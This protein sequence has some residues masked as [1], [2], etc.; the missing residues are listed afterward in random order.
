MRNILI[1][2][3]SSDSMIVSF[4]GIFTLLFP[5]ILVVAFIGLFSKNKGLRLIYKIFKFPKDVKEYKKIKNVLKVLGFSI[6]QLF[7]F[8]AI[9]YMMILYYLIYYGVFL[10]R[11]YGV[12]IHF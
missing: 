6:I 11:I 2:L 1:S 10:P 4:I 12:E 8:F 7:I 5:M 3:S 9:L